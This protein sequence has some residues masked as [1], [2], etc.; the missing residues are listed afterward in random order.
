MPF[1]L[2]PIA[3]GAGR[4]IAGVAGRAIAS[5]AVA[6]GAGQAAR[7]AAQQT[8][9]YGVG[10]TASGQMLQATKPKSQW[11]W[12][13]MASNFNPIDGNHLGDFV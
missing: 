11:D 10:R 8:A 12:K 1:P 7:A 9:R 5:R 2:I 4:V 13:D 3:L 6:S